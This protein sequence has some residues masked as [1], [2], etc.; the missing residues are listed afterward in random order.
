MVIFVRTANMPW[1]FYGDNTDNIN[2]RYTTIP[3]SYSAND[4]LN[5]TAEVYSMEGNYGGTI[6]ITDTSTLVI[7][8]CPFL[9][10]EL[11]EIL[12]FGKKY[13]KTVR[14]MHLSSLLRL[15][16]SWVKF[17]LLITVYPLSSTWSS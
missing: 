10:G 15:V 2:L 16:I 11:S 5:I 1:L 12:K 9:K 14:L 13:T 8:L 7:S 6:D 17:S 3:T 4:I